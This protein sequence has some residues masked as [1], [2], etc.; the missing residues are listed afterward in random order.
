MECLRGAQQGR[1]T[2]GK[3]KK[4]NETKLVFPPKCGYT[5]L[6]NSKPGNEYGERK[7]ACQ[8]ASGFTRMKGIDSKQF[9]SILKLSIFITNWFKNFKIKFKDTS[10]VTPVI[11]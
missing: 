4:K 9:S 6:M 11:I 3:D 10:L 1:I 8:T 2:E 7:L 5:E